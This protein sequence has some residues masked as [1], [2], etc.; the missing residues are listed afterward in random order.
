MAVR[1]HEGEGAGGAVAK[2]FTP[3]YC[4]LLY[5]DCTT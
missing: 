5:C 4:S 2:I 1:L 3:K